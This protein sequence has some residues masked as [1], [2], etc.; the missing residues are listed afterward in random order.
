M[1]NPPN[2]IA[3]GKNSIKLTAFEFRTDENI[4]GDE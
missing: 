2:D 4:C 3:N 1:T